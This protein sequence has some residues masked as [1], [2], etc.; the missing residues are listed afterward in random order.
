MNTTFEVLSQKNISKTLND[1]LGLKDY[2][3]GAL[4]E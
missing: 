2:Y 3:I 4:E 1:K